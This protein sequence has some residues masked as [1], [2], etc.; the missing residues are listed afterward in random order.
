MLKPSHSVSFTRYP[1]TRSRTISLLNSIYFSPIYSSCAFSTLS[2]GATSLSS[3]A[4]EKWVNESKSRKW[5]RTIAFALW[6]LWE[7]VHF[8]TWVRDSVCL[9]SLMNSVLVS[10]EMDCVAPYESLTSF[11]PALV[12]NHALIWFRDASSQDRSSTAQP[13]YI[14]LKTHRLIENERMMNS[15]RRLA[16]IKHITKMSCHSCP[17][18]LHTHTLNPSLGLNHKLIHLP[19]VVHVQV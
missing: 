9:R 13:Q 15:F 11:L 18:R 10:A 7:L 5:I 17:V 2:T 12:S 14:E 1:P 19:S 3:F 16:P 8:G 6:K 4:Q